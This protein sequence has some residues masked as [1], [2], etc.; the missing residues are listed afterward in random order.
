MNISFKPTSCTTRPSFSAYHLQKAASWVWLQSHCKRMD[1]F[2]R[3]FSSLKQKKKIHWWWEWNICDRAPLWNLKQFSE[4]TK[5]DYCT[6]TT[7]IHNKDVWVVLIYLLTNSPLHQEEPHH[8]PPKWNWCRSHLLMHWAIDGTHNHQNGSCTLPEPEKDDDLFKRSPNINSLWN[9]LCFQIREPCSLLLENQ[10]N[11][12]DL[13]GS[14]TIG[15]DADLSNWKLE[16][17]ANN[18]WYS[19][20]F[21]SVAVKR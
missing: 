21:L 1:T 4:A 20:I 5:K 13:G 18:F 8:Q 2:E 17:V 10:T 15:T 9:H 16:L 19:P 3:R 11:F 12:N 7:G 6:I 14:D